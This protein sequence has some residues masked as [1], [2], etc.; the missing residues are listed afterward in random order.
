M[1]PFS[2]A[3]LPPSDLPAAVSDFDERG[4]NKAECVF[5]VKPARDG[6]VGVGELSTLQQQRPDVKAPLRSRIQCQQ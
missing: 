1:K 6:A 3:L 5:R 4:N 2:R